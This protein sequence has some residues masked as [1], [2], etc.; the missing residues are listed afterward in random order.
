MP[1]DEDD[2]LPHQIVRHLDGTRG[3]ALIIADDQ[4]QLLAENAAL[5]V[6]VGDRL[7]GAAPQLLAEGRQVAGHRAGN[8]DHDFIA[9]RLRLLAQDAPPPAQ[10]DSSSGNGDQGQREMNASSYRFPMNSEA[11]NLDAHRSYAMVPHRW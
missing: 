9:R 3:I 8:A 5:G 6:H 1:V 11:G 4:P 2:T 7:L 10:A